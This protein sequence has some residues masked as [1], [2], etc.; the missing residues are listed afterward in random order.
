MVALQVGETTPACQSGQ[1]Q[2][3]F[4]P[5]VMPLHCCPELIEDIG[6]VSSE[7]GLDV[8]RVNYTGGLLSAA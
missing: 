4:S 8:A 5:N 3:R 6:G 7:R 2:E 1:Q